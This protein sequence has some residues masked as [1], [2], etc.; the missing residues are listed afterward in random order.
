ME[1]L[2][3]K[4]GTAISYINDDGIHIYLYDGRPVGFLYEEHVY[5]FSGRYLGWIYK[6]WF[7]DRLGRPTFFT[8]DSSGG[9]A[10]PARQAR[11]ARGARQA[12]PA[13][14]AR[15]ARP[16]K[17][18]RSLSWSNYSNIDYFFQ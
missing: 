10:R 9:P 14:G 4:L 5:N 7:Y 12:R 8:E 16:A 1:T 17:L 11:P 18:P 13:K 15:E 3:N 2:Y 6:G